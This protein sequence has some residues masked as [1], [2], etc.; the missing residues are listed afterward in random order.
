[1]FL[2]GYASFDKIVAVGLHGWPEVPNAK[3]SGVMVRA[4]EW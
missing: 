4:P 3:D 2:A 1:M